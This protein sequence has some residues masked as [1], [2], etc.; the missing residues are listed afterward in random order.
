MGWSMPDEREEFTLEEFVD[1]F[2][3]ERI[4]LGGPVFDL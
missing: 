2:T 1:A 3:L 4:S